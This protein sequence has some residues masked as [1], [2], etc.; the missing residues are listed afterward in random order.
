MVQGTE[1]RPPNRNKP[2]IGSVHVIGSGNRTVTECIRLQTDISNGR[3]LSL[4]VDMGTDVSLLKPDNL[5]KT[6]KFDPDC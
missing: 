6:R 2:N 5:D 1:D 4:L 3:E